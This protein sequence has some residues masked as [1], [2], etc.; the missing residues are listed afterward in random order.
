MFSEVGK[1]SR[2]RDKRSGKDNLK[3]KRQKIML[4]APGAVI[5][6]QRLRSSQSVREEW[7]EQTT[8]GIERLCR[9]AEADDREALERLKAV[10]E[11]LGAAL[12]YL[13]AA[14]RFNGAL[15]IDDSL[16]DI[17]DSRPVACASFLH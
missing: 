14:E 4:K 3:L 17:P 12:E 2:Q 1:V 8:R 16:L 5:E 7:R 9:L 11:F 15:G 6:C 13:Q 10:E